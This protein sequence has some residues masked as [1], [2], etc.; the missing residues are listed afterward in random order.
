MAVL[1]DAHQ[2]GRTQTEVGALVA[3][4]TARVMLAA[5]DRDRACAAAKVAGQTR[6]ELPA[7]ARPEISLLRGYCSAAEGNMAAAGL[8]AGLARED[9]T[10]STDTLAALDAV[11]NGEPPNLASAK[12][13]SLLD[14]RLAQ[15]IKSEA[16]S[17]PVERAEPA[18]L[19]VLARGEDTA[20]KL[21]LEAAEAA[22]RHNIIDAE[23][24]AAVYRQQSF[25]AGDLAQALT[26][27]GDA[28]TRR[29]LLFR[30]A[31]V[32]RTPLKKT[33]LVRAALDDAR[34]VGLYVPLAAALART[35]EDVQ[36]VAEIGWFAETAV[37]VMLAARRF[38][39]ARRW[40]RFAAQPGV[41]S[42][43]LA[44][45]LSHWAALIDIAD[46]SQLGGRGTALG[47]VEEIVLRG[48]FNAEALHRLASVLDALDYN[49]PHRLWEAASRSP[50]P[51]SGFLPPTGVLAELQEA[52]KA[53]DPVRTIPLAL[54][55]LGPNGP[56]GAH[57]IA[58]GD[59]IRGLRRAGLETH[60]R[61]V[62]FE[63]LF[64]LWPRASS[65]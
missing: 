65:S 52:A 41:A 48:R 45:A 22:A 56:E 21:R 9:R 28:G 47:S 1:P 26:M 50:Q 36:P 32:E 43:R 16:I 3:A 6:S 14:W 38:D 20:P 24:L 63:A 11:S 39:A 62:A 13:V 46:P 8:A 53:K 15:L 27:R 5:G 12:A 60:A 44:G 40:S 58:L 10:A 51:N 34:R 4:H 30:A 49:V 17:I 61:A 42:D 54:R 18:L 64:A 59:A 35:V 37:E 57:M 23:A 31:E 19:V 29:A 55:T 7:P 25:S 33:R 2:T